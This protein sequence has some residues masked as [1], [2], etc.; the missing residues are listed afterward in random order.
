MNAQMHVKQKKILILGEGHYEKH[1]KKIFTKMP[2]TLQN[3]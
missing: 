1:V 3:L 2:M